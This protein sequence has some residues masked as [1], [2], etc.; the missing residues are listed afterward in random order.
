[1][2]H[3]EALLLG[4]FVESTKN[5]RNPAKKHLIGT[6]SEFPTIWCT[7]I[8]QKCCNLTPIC[9]S[10]RRASICIL[11]KDAPKNLPSR[12]SQTANAFPE[13]GSWT[14]SMWRQKGQLCCIHGLWQS[15]C[16][17]YQ[18]VSVLQKL[19]R[20]S[21][22]RISLR[23]SLKAPCSWR[24]TMAC[25]GASFTAGKKLVVFSRCLCSA[26]CRNLLRRYEKKDSYNCYNSL[27]RSVLQY[28]T[29][30]TNWY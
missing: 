18:I 21:F 26:C 14:W 19:T 23:K 17:M 8:S 16:A 7:T 13:Y 20:T 6:H 30:I 25:E 1:M 12:P 2:L 10:L 5:L 29:C 27:H 9:Y 24:K 22:C 28:S 3:L 11:L 15:H 4:G